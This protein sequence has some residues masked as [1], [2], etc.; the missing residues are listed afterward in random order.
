[1]LEEG[2]IDPATPCE[3]WIITAPEPLEEHEGVFVGFFLHK[4]WCPGALTGFM[5]FSLPFCWHG[6]VST[7]LQPRLLPST[8]PW[9]GSPEG[10]GSFPAL[11]PLPCAFSRAGSPPRPFPINLFSSCGRS[12]L[13]PR[14]VP[15]GIGTGIGAGIGTGIAGPERPRP[16]ARSG[17]RRRCGTGGPGAAMAASPAQRRRWER[18]RGLGLGRAVETVRG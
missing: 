6:I 7:G 17:G 10:W 8:G 3:P 11:S 16:A 13:L 1:M 5:F 9:E 14:P 12:R 15:G 18:Y 2:D 4:S